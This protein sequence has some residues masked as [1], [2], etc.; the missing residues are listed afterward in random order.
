MSCSLHDLAGYE[1]GGVPSVLVASD[2]FVTAVESQRGALGVMPTVV[3]VPHPIQR[4]S[5]TEMESLA[6]SH[7]DAILASLLEA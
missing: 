3:Y 7:F 5:D 6:D 2:E 4:R 1:T